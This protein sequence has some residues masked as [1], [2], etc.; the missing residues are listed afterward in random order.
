MQL[1]CVVLN[2][3]YCALGVCVEGLLDDEEFELRGGRYTVLVVVGEEYINVILVSL[4]VLSA[5]DDDSVRLL[6]IVFVPYADERRPARRHGILLHALPAH[7][8]FVV[9]VVALLV[10]VVG[11]YVEHLYGAERART[12]GETAKD[13]KFVATDIAAMTG[14]RCVHLWH[15]VHDRVVHFDIDRRYV[16]LRHCCRLLRTG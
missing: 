9:R 11:L 2:Q 15:V 1:L 13:D 10:P 5:D 3:R 6:L 4:L 14:P 12:E 8:D 7:V 16:E